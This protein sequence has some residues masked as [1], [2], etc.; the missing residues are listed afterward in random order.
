MAVWILLLLA[1]VGAFLAIVT[2]LLPKLFLHNKCAISS[3]ADRGIKHTVNKSGESVLYEPS[4]PVRKYI[5]KYVLDRRGDKKVLVCKLGKKIKY[6]DYDIVVF[7]SENKVKCILNVKEALADSGYTRVIQLPD[8]AAYVSININEADSDVLTHRI[9][10]RVSIVKI[11]IYAVCSAA[12]IALT[13][14]GMQFCCSHIFGGIFVESLLYESN[15]LAVTLIIGG[16]V[17]AVDFV[18][19]L[20]LVILRN[21]KSASKRDKRI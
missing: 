8:D 15:S 9:L 13:A 20:L 4:L 10:S 11:L 12:L 21:R 6:L 5:K 19:T 16:I 14:I 3:S 18:L 7:N 17:A 2:L 1:I